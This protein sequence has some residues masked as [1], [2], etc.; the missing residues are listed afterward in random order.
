MRLLRVIC[1]VLFIVWDVFVVEIE[2]E[3]ERKREREK[4]SWWELY[5]NLLKILLCYIERIFLVMIVLNIDGKL[6]R[7]NFIWI[8]SVVVLILIFLRMIREIG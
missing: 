7:D 4:G 1:Y 3:R 6:V 8:N 2:R 5:R